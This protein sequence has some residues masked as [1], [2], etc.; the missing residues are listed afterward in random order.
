MGNCL[1]EVVRS[2]ENSQQSESMESGERLTC[3]L[4]KLYHFLRTLMD[5]LHR[6][7]TQQHN[8]SCEC[9][10]DFLTQTDSISS[11]MHEIAWALSETTAVTLAPH[12]QNRPFC[13]IG[14]AS[15]PM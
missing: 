1:A 11:R 10:R 9:E 7:H 3:E 5:D 4:S 12:T 15:A 14:A 8:K 2:A 6:A 13:A